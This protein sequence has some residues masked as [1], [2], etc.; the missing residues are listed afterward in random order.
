MI[1]KLAHRRAFSAVWVIGIVI[2]GILMQVH[3]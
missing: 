3:Q 2:L 1:A